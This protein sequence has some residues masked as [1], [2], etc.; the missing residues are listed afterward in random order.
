M[1]EVLVFDVSS[2]FGYFRKAFTTTTALTHAVIPRS[3]IEGL[4]G[5]IL[6]LSR[7]DFPDKLIES[8]I[9]VQ[10]LTEVRK[11]NMKYMHTNTK[12]WWGSAVFNYV[13]GKRTNKL[14]QFAVPA[15][16]EVL[17]NPSYRM[18]I[19]TTNKQIT[20]QLKQNLENKQSH[21]T[22]FLGTSSM[23]ASTKYVGAFE[24]KER[25]LKDF[26]SVSSIIPFTDKMPLIQLEQGSE[27][28]TEEDLTVHV[29][30][31]RKQQGT[32]RIL[33]TL[34]PGIM[35]IRD[36]LVEVKMKQEKVY[37]KFLPTIRYSN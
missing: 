13:R 5:S 27:Y 9:S 3:V 20:N 35:K 23:I 29:D 31:D 7:E 16:V 2:S 28:A 32:Y 21:Y 14:V 37:V 34:K 30:K 10:L 1:N 25:E 22:P 26:V 8:K 15:S 6:G 33:Y 11:M 12:D 36:D 19:D 24:Y 18:Y 17:V 4:V